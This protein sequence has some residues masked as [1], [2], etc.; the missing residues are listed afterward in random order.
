MSES[1]PVAPAAPASR[2]P[3]PAVRAALA[4]VAIAGVAFWAWDRRFEDTDDAQIDGSIGFVSPRVPGTLAAVRVVENQVVQAGEALAELRGQASA[5]RVMADA[6]LLLGHRA[7]SRWADFLCVKRA[8]RHQSEGRR[9]RAVLKRV[10]HPVVLPEHSQHVL[11]KAVRG[12][13]DALQ[14]RRRAAGS[15]PGSSSVV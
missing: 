15:F 6:Y 12:P 13:V 1:P 9:A 8:R 7:R 2:G 3:K 11:D 14:V 5:E 4:A 10:H